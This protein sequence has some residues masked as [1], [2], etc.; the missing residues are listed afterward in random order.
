MWKFDEFI[1]QTKRLIHKTTYK[2]QNLE[3]ATHF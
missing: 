3:E 2:K 1:E